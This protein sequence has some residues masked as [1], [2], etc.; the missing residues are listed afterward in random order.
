MGDVG[1]PDG[2][3]GVVY[4]VDEQATQLPV[5]PGVEDYLLLVLELGVDGS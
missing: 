1:E 4:R 5:V 3:V 2:G